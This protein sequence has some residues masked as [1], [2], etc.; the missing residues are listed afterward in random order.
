MVSAG[1]ADTVL[2]GDDLPG[3]GAD[4]VALRV[5]D[6]LRQV[7]HGVAL[8][9]RLLHHRHLAHVAMEHLE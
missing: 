6:L 3:L 4:L 2:T 8:A 1:Q 9:E 5:N 7:R